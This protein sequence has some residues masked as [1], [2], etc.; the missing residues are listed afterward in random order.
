MKERWTIEDIHRN[1]KQ[2]HGTEHFHVWS[3]AS[4]L[5]HSQLVYVSG[6]GAGQTV[7]AR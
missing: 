3:K 7:A 2:H 5:G 1:L 4:V 6:A